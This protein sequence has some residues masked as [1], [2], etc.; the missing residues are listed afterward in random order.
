MSKVLKHFKRLEWLKL[1]IHVII[2]WTKTPKFK[3]Q[4]CLNPNDLYINKAVWFS[5]TLLSL[6][7]YSKLASVPAGG[8]VAVAAS[9]APAAGGAAAPA[10]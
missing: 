9:G 3:V 5:Y 2:G 1:A 7:G 4:Y 6:L 8:A 10:G